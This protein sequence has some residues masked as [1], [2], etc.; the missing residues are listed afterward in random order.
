[1]SESTDPVKI[2]RDGNVYV[3]S[4]DDPP[5]NLFRQRTFE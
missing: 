3:A 1:M 4:L 5:L 2:E